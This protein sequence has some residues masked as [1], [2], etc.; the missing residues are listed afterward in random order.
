MSK[1]TVTNTKIKHLSPGKKTS[2]L[3]K[4]FEKPGNIMKLWYSDDLNSSLVFDLFILK[5]CQIIQ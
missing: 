1:T 2:R 4:D 5:Q 3:S